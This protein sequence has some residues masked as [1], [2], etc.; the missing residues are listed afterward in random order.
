MAEGGASGY[1]V[2]REAVVGEGNSW[3]EPYK[4]RIRDSGKPRKP[5]VQASLALFCV[6]SAPPV[7]LWAT[8]SLENPRFIGNSGIFGPIVD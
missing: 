6:P 3:G 8:K 5:A 1:E 2:T 7:F 4:G